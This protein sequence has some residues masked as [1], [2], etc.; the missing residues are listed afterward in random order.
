HFVKTMVAGATGID[1][2]IF[3]VAADDSIMPQTREHLDILTLL[4]VR[5]GLVALTKI[6]LV[7]SEL[8]DSVKDELQDYL[9][10][11][12][13]E[14]AP[15][16]PI[17]SITGEGFDYFY[18]SLKETIG[19][20]EPKSTEGIF[21]LPVERCFS[22][23]GFGTVVSG[24]PASGSAKVGDELVLLPAGIKSRIKA[25][26]V[27]GH[28]SK[29]VKSGQCAALNLPQIDYKNVQRGNVLTQNKYFEPGRWFLCTLKLLD[30]EA[31]LVKNGT[32]LKFHTGTSEV[33]CTVYLMESNVVCAGQN[34]IIQLR[35]EFP[36]VAGVGDQYILR[37]LSPVQTIGGGK[38]IEPVAHRVKR[39][40]E[41][42][43]EDI[44]TRAEAILHPNLFVEY[45]IQNAPG[46][47]AKINEIALRVKLEP[48]KVEAII[49]HLEDQGKVK[50]LSGDLTIHSKTLESSAKQL[51]QHIEYFHK[52]KP[53]SPG[54]QKE[55]LKELCGFEKKIFDALLDR[56]LE[57]KKLILRKDR[58]ALPTHTEQF[59]PQQQKLLSTIESQFADRLFDPP[60][61]DDISAKLRISPNDVERTV[62]ILIEQQL[63]VRV[64]QNLYFH[65]DAI[66]EAKRRT[67]RYIQTE[68][69]GR[70]ESVE[71]KYLLDTTRKYAIPLLDYMDKINLTRRAGNTRFLK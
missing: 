71:F 58:I 43:I 34:T 46:L 32:K 56:L 24:I 6:D 39:S 67:V 45:C 28:D 42:V 4:G 14:D 66:E 26:Q 2:V 21:R 61:I 22:A 20:I 33:T 23:K 41:G 60:K 49:S 53:E 16:C 17:S 10:G 7:S 8:V 50:R 1:G 54:V 48:D 36:I 63:L 57:Q 15:I 29:V 18:T 38:I 52:N 59:D 37:S 62:R 11:T 70:L 30:I 69:N 31:A 55:R 19:Q 35:T 40:K 9:R 65:S 13:L 64:E 44:R 3:V 25:I 27:Y 5:H 68:G 47:A 12:F 51:Q